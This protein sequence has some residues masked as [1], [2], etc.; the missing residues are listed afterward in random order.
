MANRPPSD[1]ATRELMSELRRKRE[2]GRRLRIAGAA[3]VAV[4]V[5]AALAIASV[6]ALSGGAPTT[7]TGVTG[8]SSPTTVTTTGAQTTPSTAPH[9]PPTTRK[10]PPR[11]PTTTA[12]ATPTTSAPANATPTTQPVAS[13][14]SVAGAVV[15]VDP[16]H[17]G[18]GNSAQEPVGPGSST[19]KDKVTSGTSGVSSGTP[20]SKIALAIG[21]KLRDALQA[22]GIKVIMTRTSENVDLSNIQRTKIAN[23]AHAALYIRVHADGATSSSTHGIHTLYPATISGWTDDIAVVSKRAAQL[24]QNAL[25]AA[26]GAADRGLDARS[27]M[28]GFNWSD[29]PVIIPELGFMTN[30]AEDR[31]LNSASYQQKLANALAD[32]AV[33]FIQEQR[34]G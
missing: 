27:D 28:T 32:A 26:T 4:L 19:T 16:G 18:R 23:A 21:L 11:P 10:P 9:G 34:G 17:Q 5:V 15:V 30:P 29:V 8:T 1:P 31:L 22:R 13:A 6:S 14:G 12:P 33:R 3:G 20:E 25:V 7:T 2:R 24:A